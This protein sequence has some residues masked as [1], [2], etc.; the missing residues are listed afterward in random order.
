VLCKWDVIPG[1]Q[2]YQLYAPYF[3]NGTGYPEDFPQSSPL[4]AAP[5]WIAPT[6]AGKMVFGNLGAFAD[7]AAQA[8]DGQIRGTGATGQILL[9]IENRL[10]SQLSG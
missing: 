7:G 10:F 3:S 2:Q 1:G 6:S 8:S 4:P 5:P 9:D